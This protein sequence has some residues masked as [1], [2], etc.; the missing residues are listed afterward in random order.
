MA[1]FRGG[2][3]A[4]S[5]R[6][7]ALKPLSKDGIRSELEPVIGVKGRLGRWRADRADLR[8]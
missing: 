3:K 1:L 7:F 4:D 5:H 2:L 6:G 8:D